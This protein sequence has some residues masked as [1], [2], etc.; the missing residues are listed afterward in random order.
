MQ[1]TASVE[2]GGSGGKPSGIKVSHAPGSDT[3]QKEGFHYITNAFKLQTFIS[4]ASMTS[5]GGWLKKKALDAK[6]SLLGGWNRNCSKW[7]PG[8]KRCPL[9]AAPH[10]AASAHV[11]LPSFTNTEPTELEEKGKAEAHLWHGG[12][13]KP[14]HIS[15]GQPGGKNR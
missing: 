14:Q 11:I 8:E 13:V 12:A 5:C 9:I 3:E 10:R 4:Q 15:W 6:P 1:L 7:G 2:R